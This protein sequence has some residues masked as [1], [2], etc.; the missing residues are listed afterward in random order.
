M[1]A[2]LWAKEIPEEKLTTL[3]SALVSQLGLLGS[4]PDP[5]GCFPMRG[6]LS[7]AIIGVFTVRV[8][9]VHR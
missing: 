6:G 4:S 9:D 1:Y 7:A 3:T 8:S 5:V 2:S